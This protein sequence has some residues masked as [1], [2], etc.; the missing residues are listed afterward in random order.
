M[1]SYWFLMIVMLAASALAARAQSPAEGQFIPP[2][3]INSPHDADLRAYFPLEAQ[4]ARVNGRAELSCIVQLD[5]TLDCVV[6]SEEPAGHG[7]GEA[8]LQISRTLRINPATRGGVPVE[9]L[10]LSVPLAFQ[11]EW[12]A[13]SAPSDSP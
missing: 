1:R 8:A 4:H 10:R 3:W 2:S 6:A 12:P 13:E 7:F 9:G 11:W 5:T